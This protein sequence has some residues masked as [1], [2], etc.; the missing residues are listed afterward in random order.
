MFL[1]G[2]RVPQISGQELIDAMKE[3]TPPYVLDV[4]TVPEF[5]Q[6][7]IS[8]AHLIPLNEMAKRLHEIPKGQTVV[9]VCRSGSRSRIAAKTLAKAGY[10]VKNLDGGMLAWPGPVKR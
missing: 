2:P 9:T 3:K 6:G 4:R 7:H 1:F 10:T 8:G 5:R